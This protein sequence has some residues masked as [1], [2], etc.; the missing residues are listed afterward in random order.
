MLFETAMILIL[1]TI[2]DGYHFAI[3]RNDKNLACRPLLVD[4]EFPAP[5]FL[6]GSRLMYLLHIIMPS[7]VHLSN[8]GKRHTVCK[9]VKIAAISVN[10]AWLS[11]VTWLTAHTAAKAVMVKFDTVD[12]LATMLSRLVELAPVLLCLYARTANIPAKN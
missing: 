11:N 12:I 6:R 7:R 10:T 8:G 2:C 3:S 5:P 9:I 4:V 1:S